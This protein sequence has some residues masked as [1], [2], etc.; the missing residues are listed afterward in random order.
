MIWRNI[1][2]YAFSIISPYSGSISWLK[3]FPIK[4][5]NLFI[6]CNQFHGF[7]CPGDARSQTRRCFLNKKNDFEIIICNGLAQDCSNSIANALELLQSC[8][9]P[10][11]YRIAALSLRQRWGHD[12][13]V[14]LFSV[15]CP[16]W[17]II[18]CISTDPGSS[19]GLTTGWTRTLQYHHIDISAASHWS[20]TR[21][22][23]LCFQV[24]SVDSLV[25]L[26]TLSQWLHFSNCLQM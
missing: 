23:M 16:A 15:K 12:H 18:L 7:W 26:T 2:I 5:K 11:I 1:Y 20:N 19:G 6:E 13:S 14:F 21:P 8:I 22:G 9:K 10:S 17:D 3:S 24:S 25:S 4:G